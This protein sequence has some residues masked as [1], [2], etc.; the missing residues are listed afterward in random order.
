MPNLS[1]Y[2]F[3]SNRPAG[4]SVAG[5]NKSAATEPTNTTS[6]SL[7]RSK[8]KKSSS[9][10]SSSADAVQ[11]ATPPAAAATEPPSIHKLCNKERLKHKLPPL[12]RS[13]A[14]D[15]MAQKAVDKIAKHD[16]PTKGLG[17]TKRLAQTLNTSVVS[18]NI[19]VGSSIKELH[20]KTMQKGSTSRE[21]ILHKKYEAFGMATATSKKTGQL[22]LVQIFRGKIKRAAV[23]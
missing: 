6:Q 12:G 16:D 17:S 9:S 21:K 8:K 14:M 13:K 5:D 19:E 20:Q 10:P 22:Y 4:S 3:K 18:R 2:L 11:P 7:L 23:V 1:T 15:R